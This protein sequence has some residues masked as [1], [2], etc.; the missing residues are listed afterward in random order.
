MDPGCGVLAL[1]LASPRVHRRGGGLHGLAPRPGRR[2]HRRGVGPAP[3]HVRHRRAERA[4]RGNA[5]PLRGLPRLEAGTH[6]ERRLRP[7]P[8]RHLRRADGLRLPLQQVR[9][10]DRARRLGGA[11][12]VD[13]LAL[14]ELGPARRGDLGGARRPAR[15][16]VLPPDVLGCARARDSNRPAT[17]DSPPTS[18]RGA[19][20][21]MPSTT[22][23]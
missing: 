11:L 17:A 22:R 4:D 12:G 21:A 20:P 9:P 14:R 3:D 15:L 19:L 7:A 10:P 6:R 23:S 8:A 16:H 13:R 18:T 5:R 2:A 1:R